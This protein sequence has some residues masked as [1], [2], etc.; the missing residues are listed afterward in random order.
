MRREALACVSRQS[1]Q[2][3]TFTVPQLCSSVPTRVHYRGGCRRTAFQSSLDEMRQH[4]VLLLIEFCIPR[5]R[6]DVGAE[7]LSSG[8]QN[9][10]ILWAQSRRLHVWSTRF[11][12]V[13]ARRSI[14][15]E[16]G[17]VGAS[18]SRHGKHCLAGFSILSRRP[19]ACR[20]SGCESRGGIDDGQRGDR[21]RPMHSECGAMVLLRATS[22]GRCAARERL[23]HMCEYLLDIQLGAC[24]CL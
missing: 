12:R 3:S 1:P 4:V 9:W 2:L 8:G 18:G 10:W 23:W 6:R 19:R 20:C 11:S 21:L 13:S 24:V 15:F 5:L 7:I 17:R 22:R 14:A 16:C